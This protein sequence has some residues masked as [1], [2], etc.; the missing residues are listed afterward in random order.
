MTQIDIAKL[1]L[2]P[3][4][5]VCFLI[6]DL[7]PTE[8]GTHT[9]GLVEMGVL[10][11]TD[12]EMEAAAAAL[13]VPIVLQ[14]ETLGALRL[15][16]RVGRFEGEITYSERTVQLSIPSVRDSAEVDAGALAVAVQLVANLSSL[17]QAASLFAASRLVELKND[18]W[19]GEDEEEVSE[20][21]F[22]QRLALAAVSA[23]ADGEVSLYYD[24]GDLFFGHSIDVRGVVGGEFH[25]ASLSG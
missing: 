25:D 10:G 9:A 11:A 7:E 16:R 4:S 1:Q 3:T 2:T 17:D 18:S 12:P 21:D 24:D 23:E 15:D 22:Q 20:A 14:T 19:L 5:V 13:R 6:Q 8:R